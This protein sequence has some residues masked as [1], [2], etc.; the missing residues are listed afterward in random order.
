MPSSR[1]ILATTHWPARAGALSWPGSV[2]RGMKERQA[3]DHR[4]DV[5]VEAIGAGR[6]QAHARERHVELLGDQHRQRGVRALA[7]LAA[8]HRQPTLPSAPILIQPLRPTSPASTGSASTAPRRS[9]GGSRPQPTTSAPAAPK[10][11]SRSA[12]APHPA[13][14]P[15]RAAQRRGSPRAGAG[16][17]R[18]GRCCRCAA[19]M[20]ASF[21][22]GFR[23]QRGRRHQMPLAVA[24]L[25]HL[26]LDPCAS[27]AGAARR[28]AERLDGDDAP[29]RD[30]RHGIDARRARLAVD[31]DRAG[32]AGGNAAAE[33]GA[34][35]AEQVAQGP[36]QRQAGSARSSASRAAAVDEDLHRARSEGPDC[37][38]LNRASRAR[39]GTIS[40]RIQRRRTGGRAPVFVSLPGRPR[41][42]DSF[43]PPAPP[44]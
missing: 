12:R 11:L 39:P 42:I 28:R 30:R 18:S 44:L 38:R 25:R 27:A 31:M 29:A 16:R 41:C 26:M 33:L 24:A 40:A 9:R 7:H 4:R 34:G 6:D 20:S 35:Q 14:S 37:G 22:L 13:S 15:R 2:S 23:Q 10:P 19:S 8:V 32:A 21:G 1:A 36:E 17:C 43:A 3:R 5:A